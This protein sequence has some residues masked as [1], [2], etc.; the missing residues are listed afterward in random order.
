MRY[1]SN[2]QYLYPVLR[3]DSDDYDTSYSLIAT[4]D[5]PVYDQLDGV[6]DVSVR[7]DLS[8]P[9]LKEAVRSRRAKC[10]AMVYCGSTLYR[11][12][13]DPSSSDPF[14][15]RGRI[16]VSRLK[17]QV[18]I[19]PV[20]LATSSFVHSTDTAHREYQ[21]QPTQIARLAPLAT[22]LPWIFDIDSDVRP[23]RSIFRMQI[24]DDDRLSD[25]EFDVNVDVGSDYVAI[26]VNRNTMSAFKTIRETNNMALPTVFMSALLSVLASVKDIGDEVDDDNCEWLRCVRTQLRNLNID[27]GGPEDEGADTLFF[28]AQR[29]LKCPFAFVFEDLPDF[30]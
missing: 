24:V 26:L 15:A 30:E 5:P 2:R 4:C 21:R 23:V 7:F 6:I 10:A 9:R 18:Q 11:E 20:I 8:E 16:P 22:D 27:I 17:N 28:A 12:K 25:G 14:V 19:H 3:P 13:L 29:L 1:R